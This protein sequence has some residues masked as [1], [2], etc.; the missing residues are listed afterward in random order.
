[1]YTP[2][3]KNLGSYSNFS[4]LNGYGFLFNGQES[5]NEAKGNNNS[6]T[7]TFR[8]YD[9]RIGRFLSVDPLTKTYPEF[10]PY[11]FA[12]NRVIEGNDLEG[13]ELKPCIRNNTARYGTSALNNRPSGMRRV[14]TI[15]DNKRP[16]NAG[17]RKGQIYAPP[18]TLPIRTFE[19]LEEPEG[20]SSPQANKGNAQNAA[21]TQA[22]AIE[23]IQEYFTLIKK[24]NVKSNA[25]E[26]PEG[27]PEVTLLT[28]NPEAIILLNTM[29][30]AYDKNLKSET[31][32]LKKPVLAPTKKL[33][34]AEW[35]K[36]QLES[37]G[38]ELSVQLIKI[39][40]GPSPTEQII[41]NIENDPNRQRNVTTETPSV[42][43]STP[44][45]E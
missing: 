14:T 11:A 36:Y 35:N 23:N 32:K 44:T 7:Y 13:L 38:Y 20:I 3:S 26:T 9:P 18:K 33:P 45:G 16:P 43:Y 27:P 37:A 10:T 42:I 29:Q 30:Q 24:Q 17:T 28:D 22:D 4:K 6:Y 5:D 39:K 1:M 34:P 8:I 19:Y 21:K 25:Y 2:K 12:E 40:M 41:K 31:D 15:H